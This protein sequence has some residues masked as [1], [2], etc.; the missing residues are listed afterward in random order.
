M[1]MDGSS[2]SN[3]CG[4]IFTLSIIKSLELIFISLLV[5]SS[6]PGSLQLS[7][8]VFSVIVQ[9]RP[10]SFSY[11]YRWSSIIFPISIISGM[12]L[13]EQGDI[14]LYKTLQRVSELIYT[15]VSV[16]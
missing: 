15:E 2:T 9:F 3:K 10:F 12:I 5:F 6:V 11:L 14:F 13:V 7:I 16:Y 8:Q 4:T 1:M